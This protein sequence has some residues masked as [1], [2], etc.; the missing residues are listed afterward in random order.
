MSAVEATVHIVRHL[1][2]LERA[3]CAADIVKE[4]QYLGPSLGRPLLSDL[5]LP[6]LAA[7]AEAHLRDRLSPARDALTGLLDARAFGELFAAHARHVAGVGGEAVAVRLTVHGAGD[8]RSDRQT[9]ADLRALA[10]A[11]TG[12]VAEGDYVG[13]VDLM[14][15]AV[16]PRHG[17]M[18]GARSVAARLADC[19]REAFASA[20]RGLRIEIE[21]Q[22]AAGCAHEHTEIAV[23]PG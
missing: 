22:D 16:L 6:G 5:P 21:L 9:A 20:E 15:L 19:C 23:G 3:S 14:S 18:R 1:R 10:A 7:L 13:R 12:C 2:R 17:G 11:C 4:L 8:P